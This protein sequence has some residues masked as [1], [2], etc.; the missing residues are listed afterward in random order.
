LGHD[1]VADREAETRP[2]TGRLRG[3]E[4]L[5][6]LVFDFGW[7]ANAIVTDAKFYGIAEISRRYLQSRLEI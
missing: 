5:K 2:F 3:E 6:E 7:N 1:V 4:R